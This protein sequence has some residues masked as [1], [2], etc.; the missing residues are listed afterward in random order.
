MSTRIRAL[1]LA[2]IVVAILLAGTVFLIAGCTP[3]P[4]PAGLT[5]IPTLSPGETATL[6][7]ALQ[8]VGD[9]DEASDLETASAALGA[10][11]YLLHCTRCHG[12]LGE[13]VDAPPL[14]NNQFLQTGG[15]QN[16]FDTIADG[17]PG[18]RMP[19]W[20]QKNGG[21]LTDAEIGD[22]VSY[23]HTLQQVSAVPPATPT[24]PE[25][26]ETPLPPGAPTPAPARPSLPGGPGPAVS[27]TGRRAAGL[28]DFGTFCAICHGPE[29]REGVG[30]PN[31]G[32][33][34]GIV[35]ELNP[36]DPT[37]ANSDPKTFAANL[38]LFLQHG[39]VPEGPAPLLMMPSFGDSQLLS[40]QRIADLIAYVMHLNGVDQ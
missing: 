4:A 38:D 36:I 10:P 31:P 14:R 18:T 28:L 6:V 7:P 5:P 37:I 12:V 2:A 40:Q 8:G 24:P 3:N 22:V 13:G 26:T 15:D 21:A 16:I 29:G 33:D 19:A 39:S 30:A 25:P 23:L 32:S 35:P 1:P 11:L 17:R 9:L 20:L 34:D 27:L